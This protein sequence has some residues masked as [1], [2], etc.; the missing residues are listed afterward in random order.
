MNASSNPAINPATATPRYGTKKNRGVQTRIPPTVLPRDTAT[1]RFTPRRVQKVCICRNFPYPR[2]PRSLRDT[3][4][5]LAVHR[6]PEPA[7]AAGAALPRL[8]LVSFAI[9]ARDRRGAR[10]F[11]RRLADVGNDGLS[12]L[13]K[14]DMGRPSDWVSAGSAARDD[15]SPRADARDQVG[16]SEMAAPACR[17]ELPDCQLGVSRAGGC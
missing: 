9:A 13:L 16:A 11:P 14:R 7:P 6:Y 10:F 8:Q 5:H 12:P 1:P 17:A 2:T 3:L 15:R 4:P